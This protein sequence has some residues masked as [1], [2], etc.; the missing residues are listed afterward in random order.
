MVGGQGRSAMARI[1][2]RKGMPS[3]ALS[4]A[5]FTERLK[6]RF[7]D[8]AFNLLQD[9][10]GDIIEAAWDGYRDSRKSPRTKPAG[11]GYADPKYDLSIEWSAAKKAVADAERAQ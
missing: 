8:P 3:T 10:I 2:A 4:K 5:E 1:K 6:R 9:R 11:R 7:Y